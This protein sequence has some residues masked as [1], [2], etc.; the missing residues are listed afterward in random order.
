MICIYRANS[1]NLRHYFPAAVLLLSLLK[2]ITP[3]LAQWMHFYSLL[4]PRV[5]FSADNPTQVLPFVLHIPGQ[6]QLQLDFSFLNPIPAHLD[7]VPPGSPALDSCSRML[8][9]SFWFFSG[10]R[11]HK[12]QHN[13]QSQQQ[14]GDTQWTAAAGESLSVCCRCFCWLC[15]RAAASGQSHVLIAT[16]RL[17]RSRL[18]EPGKESKTPA[19]DKSKPILFCTKM[20]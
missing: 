13:K 4:F 19:G 2:V 6:M 7:S 15:L 3:R 8:P 10:T 12:L 1:Y 11:E 9:L 20:T 5:P 17:A 18:S 16:I 14:P